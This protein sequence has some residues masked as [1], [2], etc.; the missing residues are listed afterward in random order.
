M[1]KK[2][3]IIGAGFFGCAAAV[4]LQNRFDVTLFDKRSDLLMGTA[5]ANV[6]RIHNGPHYPRSRETAL[7][8]REGYVKFTKE[9]SGCFNDTFL[10]IYAISSHKSK[11]SLQQLYGFCDELSIPH[12]KTSR[13]QL[14]E[15]IANCDGAIVCPE[16]AINIFKT[17]EVYRQ[18]LNAE[19]VL[20]QK[21]E[22]SDIE[23]V[24]DGFL[25]NGTHFDYLINSSFVDMNLLHRKANTVPMP[26]IFQKT[27]CFQVKVDKASYGLTVLDGRFPTVFPSYWS[28]ESNNLDSFILYH[29][30]HSVLE[31]EECTRHPFRTEGNMVRLLERYEAV[32]EE[33]Q[34]YIPGFRKSIQQMKCLVGDRVIRPRVRNSDTRVSEILNPIPNYYIL[35]NGKI[36]YSLCIAEQL[37]EALTK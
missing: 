2:V 8:C 6:Y 26:L 15:F 25:I 33:A 20:N 4:E 28:K 23:I 12:T 13:E 22:A 24:K 34:K 10:N 35:F 17:R 37:R 3:A 31:E 29:V 18:R 7:Q 19:L 1:S 11:T 32:L 16:G 21:I 5:Q 27:V 36:D 30:T 9:F 14:P